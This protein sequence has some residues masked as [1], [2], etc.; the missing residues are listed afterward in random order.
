MVADLHHGRAAAPVAARGVALGR[1][2]GIGGVGDARR[3]V[4]ATADLAHQRS[5]RGEVG[6]HS[7]GRDP[8][9]A[10]IA[11]D[12]PV[13]LVEDHDPVVTEAL[14]H[15]GADLEVEPAHVD[16]A[17][18]LGHGLV[19]PG[20]RAHLG[21]GAGEAG[22]QA[23]VDQL[24]LRADDILVHLARGIK[25]DGDQRGADQKH[26]DRDGHDETARR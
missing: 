21:K 2:F 25:D 4:G 23:V 18:A 14:G 26:H 22:V 1:A 24:G 15:E 17:A 9:L 8:A 12:G 11:V 20:D 16:G 6:L 3:D 10:V 13:L 7:V 5:H 19:P